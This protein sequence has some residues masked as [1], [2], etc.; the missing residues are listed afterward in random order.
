M[1]ALLLLLHS[2]EAQ[3]AGSLSCH[4]EA[5]APTRLSARRFVAV[6]RGGRTQA[7]P[8]K[9]THATCTSRAAEVASAQEE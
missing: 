9:A 3:L 4:G 1:V 6:G 2:T 5:V 8:G 7:G